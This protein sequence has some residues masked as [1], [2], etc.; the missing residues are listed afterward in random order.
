MKTVMLM[1]SLIFCLDAFATEMRAGKVIYKYKKHEKFEMD[2]IAIEGDASNPGDLSIDPRFRTKFRNKLPG[3][4]NF[5]KEMMDA[6]E[7][8]R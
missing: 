7:A 8:I 3:R 6:I 1:L 4:D 2:D 5:N